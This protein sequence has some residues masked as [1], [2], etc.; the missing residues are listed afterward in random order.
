MQNTF[1]KLMD[2][3]FQVQFAGW[4]GS[5]LPSP[6][7]GMHSQYAEKLDATNITGLANPIIDS[8]IIKYDANLDANERIKILQ[9]IDKLASEEYHWAFGWGAPYG[10]RCLNWNK[11]GMPEHGIGYS[12]NWLTP[13]YYWWI[14]PEKKQAL[15]NARKNETIN[16]DHSKEIIDYWNRLGKN[17]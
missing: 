17:K 2:R 14:D 5:L 11:F 10:Y 16:L 8:L 12:G 13:I 1:E 3:K 9:Q 15:I 4:T 7:G 6:K